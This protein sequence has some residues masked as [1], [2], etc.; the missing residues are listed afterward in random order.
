M[1]LFLSQLPPRRY[2]PPKTVRTVHSRVDH[3]VKHCHDVL[4]EPSLPCNCQ[5]DINKAV[6]LCALHLEQ[7]N[8]MLIATIKSTTI[9][10]HLKAASS[11][12]LH[13]KQLEWLLET[14]DLEAQCIK[15]VLSEVKRWE[16]MPNCR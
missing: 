12:S 10:R 5:S 4:I 6:V 11:V 2:Q 1:S 14:R 16:S 8:T 9:K 7:G 15:E 13:H 3:C